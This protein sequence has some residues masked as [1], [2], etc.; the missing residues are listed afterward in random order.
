MQ[1]LI[2]SFC[3]LELNLKDLKYLEKEIKQG[4]EGYNNANRD[5][6]GMKILSQKLELS[7]NG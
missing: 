3:S 2:H 4:N 6:I 1:H 7:K 5:E